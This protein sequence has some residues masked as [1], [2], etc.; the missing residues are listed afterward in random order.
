MPNI[1]SIWSQTAER[2]PFAAC[3]GDIKTDILIIG[4]GITGILCAYMLKRA[5]VDCLLVEADRICGGIT[6]NTTAKIT[7]QHGLIYDRMARRFGYDTARGYWQVQRAAME[8]YRVLSEVFPCEYEEQDAYVYARDDRRK[9]E[10][11]AEALRRMGCP[12]IVTDTVPLPFSV[13][14]AVGMARQAQFHPLKFAFAMA[15]GLPIYENTKV[16]ELMPNCAVTEHGRIVSQKTIVATH[17]PFLNKHGG[18][19]LKL[20]QHRSYVLALDNAPTV[21][22]M[23]VD[24]DDR[25]MSFRHHQGLLLVG[26]GGH[27]TGKQGGNWRELEAFSRK[28][29]PTAREACR[30]ATQDC[31]TL[32]DIPYIGPYSRRTPSLYVATG[33]NK[34]G[35]TSAMA[36]AMILTDLVQEKSNE[37]APL[38]DPSRGIWRPQL[39]INGAESLMGLLRPTVPRCP[40]LG[41]A[42]TYNA[43]EHS[44]DCSCHGSRFTE[45]GEVIDNPATDDK[46]QMPRS[47]D[48]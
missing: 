29:Y 32:D 31:M 45:A 15:R 5:G 22:G 41:C 24:E 7:A 6:Q 38:F 4:G 14:G 48:R 27:R 43:A 40:H 3:K 13:A 46:K 9:I 35:M 17:F 42:L 21:E 28:H 26:G 2:P 25:G 8:Q 39:A 11:E 33:F 18:Y 44:W 10:R 37:Y 12:A 30:W 47:V 16:V 36:A 23:Y 1:H 20:Y 19:F 34:W